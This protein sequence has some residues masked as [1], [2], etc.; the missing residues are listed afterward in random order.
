MY[1]ID[2]NLDKTVR[3]HAT[4]IHELSGVEPERQRLLIAGKELDEHKTFA[5]YE[6]L[7]EIEKVTKIRLVARLRGC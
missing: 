3:H 1:E 6:H 7:F 5:E 4:L 2:V